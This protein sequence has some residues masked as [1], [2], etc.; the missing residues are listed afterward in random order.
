MARISTRDGIVGTPPPTITPATTPPDA[1]VFGLPWVPDI[2]FAVKDPALIEQEVI[3]DYEAAFLAL[4]NIAKSLAPGDPVRLHLLVVC[5]WLSQQRVIIDFTGKNNLL[6]YAVGS[7]LDNLAALL[8]E[9]TLRLAAAP[10]ITTLR[11]TLSAALA[12]TATIPAGTQCQAPNAVVFQTDVAGVIPAGGLTCDVSATALVAGAIGSGFTAGQ[13]NSVINWNQPFGISVSNTT[14]T[15]GGSDAETD[16]QYRYRIWLAIESFS[17]CGPHDA[18]E[19][20]A[21]SAHPDIIQCVVYSAPDIAGEVWLYPLLT[22]GIIPGTD[23]L[24]L[25]ENSCSAATRRPVTDFVTAKAATQHIYTLVMAWYI[26]PVNEVL[27]DTITA[28]VNAAVTGWILWQRSAI[29]RDIICDELIKR[30][31]EAGASRVDITTP[32]ALFTDLAYDELA[33]HDPL[34]APVVSYGGLSSPSPDIA[35]K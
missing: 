14:T 13:V 22:G 3:A 34:I 19:F 11:F 16:D 26:D 28:N 32:S 6:K 33:V 1:P 31:L 8:G 4:T 9:R 29:G 12:T 18:Y 35:R 15:S 7:Y 30:C 20:W 5:D 24:T 10:A 17:T 27:L 21:L 25:V 2:D 23:I